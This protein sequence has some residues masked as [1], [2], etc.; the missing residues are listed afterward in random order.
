MMPV[1][2]KQGQVRSI[3]IPDDWTERA[4]LRESLVSPVIRTFEAPGKSS[5]QIRLGYRGRP[6]SQSAGQAFL[7]CLKEPAHALSG[8]ELASLS[9]ILRDMGDALQ[10]EINSAQTVDINRK[11]ALWVEGRWKGEPFW[12]GTLFFDADAEGRVVQEV[13]C[14]C[15]VSEHESFSPIFKDVLHSIQWL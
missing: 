2:E 12:S 14:F 7:S 1:V 3:R 5:V 11:R 9:A 6:E 8:T 4:P 10:F 15:D 13:T